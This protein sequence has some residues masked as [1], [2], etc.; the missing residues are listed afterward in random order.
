MTIF[1]FGCITNRIKGRYG[2]D[3]FSFHSGTNY[4][5]THPTTANYPN[6]TR[7]QFINANFT[8]L[9]KAWRDI[10]G[11]TKELWNDYASRC[12]GAA[13]GYNKFISHNA[14]LL[15]TCHSDLIYRPAPP[16]R[17]GPPAHVR[18]LCVFAMSSTQ[19][20]ISWTK[21]DS[22]I[23]YVTAHFRLH[24]YFCNVH[25]AYGCCVADGY[26]PSFRFIST[27]KSDSRCTVFNHTWPTNTRMWFHCRSI[28]KFG[29]KS[30]VTHSINYLN[31]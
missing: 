23:L 11:T 7:Q 29:R 12:K 3:V 20:C 4:T 16:P 1:Q 30:P 2:A 6:S 27:V 22:T 17:P 28:D 18:G 26:R 10:S 9:S 8:A 15:N 19:V 13:S 24:K 5:R 21:P 25:P 14:N 31:I